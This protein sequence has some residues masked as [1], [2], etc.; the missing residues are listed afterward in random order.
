MFKMT[1]LWLSAY[2]EAQF[3]CDNVLD[4]ILDLRGRRGERRISESGAEVK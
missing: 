3:G 2:Y 1:Y 4:T